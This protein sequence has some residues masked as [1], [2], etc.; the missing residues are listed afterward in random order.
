M[1][2]KKQQKTNWRDR[3]HDDVRELDSAH[4]LPAEDIVEA[5]NEIAMALLVPLSTGMVIV[6]ISG[7]QK[8]KGEETSPYTLLVGDPVQ[9]R[10][11]G[12]TRHKFRGIDGVPPLAMVPRDS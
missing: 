12:L 11:R 1:R 3:G 4:K 9:R 6:S 7:P 10:R 2:A 8:S 5:A